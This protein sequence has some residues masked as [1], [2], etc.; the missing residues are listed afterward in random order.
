MPSATTNM[1]QPAD[2]THHCVKRGRVRQRPEAAANCRPIL[3]DGRSTSPANRRPTPK[4]RSVGA[5]LPFCGY[6]GANLAW[7]IELLAGRSGGNWSIDAPSF[8]SGAENLGVE[9]F[10]LAIDV[11]KLQHD[12]ASSADTH[13]FRLGAQGARTPGTSREKPVPKSPAHQC[14]RGAADMRDEAAGASRQCETKRSP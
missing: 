9:M 6:K 2:G 3:R 4:L 14:P 1:A 10:V 13:V 12:F 7:M 11:S 5:M 8:D